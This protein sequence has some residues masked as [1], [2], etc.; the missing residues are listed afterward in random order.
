MIQ[1]GAACA[2]CHSPDGI[3]IAAYNFDDPDI[4]RRAQPHVG[5][6]DAGLLVQ[7]FH[8]LR[9]KFGLYPLRDPLQDRPLQ[10]GGS[11]L[12]GN[13]PSERDLAFGLELKEKL[14]RLFGRRIETIDEAKAAEAELL[15]LPVTNLRVGIPFNRLSED[16]AHGNEHSTIA[17]WLPEV[18]PLIPENDLK[19]WY[20]AEDQ[21][22]ASPSETQLH[23][24]LEKHR[25]LLNTNLMVGL[26]AMSVLKFRALLVW[27]DR[28]RHRT[29]ADPLTV[30]HELSLYSNDNPIWEVGDLARDMMGRDPSSFGMDKETQSKK[31]AGA[32]F[33]EQLHQLRVAWFWAGWLSDQGLFKT[34][35]DDKI[36]LGMWISQSL[37]Q[38]GPYP[39]HN[40]FSNARRQAVVSNDPDAWAESIVRK[41][42]I[43][44]F[45]G[46]RSF[47]YQSKDL[48]ED[49]SYRELTITF[50]AN[51]FRMNLLLLKDEI[52]RTHAVWVKQ[53]ARS[54]VQE[55]VRFLKAYDPA[56]LT[57]TQILEQELTTLI[58][59]AKERNNFAPQL[60]PN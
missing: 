20:A 32:P 17:Q 35:H 22:L 48:P 39:I 19:S 54:N 11:I 38:D 49:P 21:Y 36:R 27:Q 53:S 6:A 60:P 40:V 10:P 42:R 16:V 14:P 7:Y 8:A 30:S 2:T 56:N 34:S 50:T 29:E 9:D 59:G 33:S 18:A 41:R 15:R 23:V 58:D 4:I 46:L 24:L 45:A 5:S 12:A 52:L 47:G 51:C 26:K 57:S 3:E 13:T 31:L 25:Q 28:M 37:S 55:L 1:G 43:W 44:D